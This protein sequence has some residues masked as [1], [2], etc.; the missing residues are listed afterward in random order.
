MTWPMFPRECCYQ[1]CTTWATFEVS[2][3]GSDRLNE[4]WYCCDDH[5]PRCMQWL[6]G[7]EKAW[8]FSGQAVTIVE[9]PAPKA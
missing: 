8:G 1:G 7:R 4:H 2:T 3:P 5:Q 9:L 6:I